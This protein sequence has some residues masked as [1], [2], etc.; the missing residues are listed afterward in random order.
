M[1]VIVVTNTVALVLLA[2][3]VVGLLR[4]HAEILRRLGPEEEHG[5]H[6][7]RVSSATS[8]NLELIDLP[9]PRDAS[10]PASDIVGETPLGDAVKITVRGGKDTLVTFLSSGCLTCMSLWDG[11]AHD[12]EPLPGNARIVVVTK[13]RSMESPS[14]L[15]ELAPGAVPV[16][17][18][19][20]AWEG[21]GIA[22]S[23]YFVYVDG[24]TGAV[25][26]EG[27]A[28]SWEQVRSLLRDAMADE[29][30]AR[31]VGADRG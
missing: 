10:P 14:R 25:R 20:E 24:R 9:G 2:M 6:A 21:Y 26:S 12:A 4:S 19:Q 31:R 3:L 16:V 13:G 30:L 27:A 8:P 17:M 29:E 11:I 1:T 23:P 15:R 18:S 28:S 7:Q 5:D 22:M